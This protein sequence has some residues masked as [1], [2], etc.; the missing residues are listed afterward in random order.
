MV[1]GMSSPPASVVPVAILVR[2]ST[3]RQETERQEAELRAVAAARGWSVVEVVEEAGV[4]GAAKDRPGL[5]RVLVLARSGAVQKVLVHEVSR[6]ARR[7]SAAH[8]FVEALTDLGVSLY[9]HAQGLETLLASGKPNPA[10]GVMFALLAEMARSER[11]TLR[12][13]VLSGLAAA[14][15]AGKV[16]GRPAGTAVDAEAFLRLHGDV[17]RLLRAGQS[18]RHS[19]AISGKATGTVQK[20]RRALGL[21]SA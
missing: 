15:R 11:E 4:S 6:V 14:R 18:V 17:V 13:R 16:L 9:W 20:V 7:N 10:A 5:D 8:A 3:V 1:V 19:A 2:V 21:A 12:E